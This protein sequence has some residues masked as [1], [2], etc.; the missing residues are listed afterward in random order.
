MK[1]YHGSGCGDPAEPFDDECRRPCP[2]PCPRFCPVPGPKGDTG[3]T[4][5]KGDMG[6]TG[7][8]GDTGATGPKGD[9]G[10]TGPKGDTGSTGPKG[11]TGATGPKGDMGV[12]TCPCRSRGELAVN[13]GMEA[14][15]G[16]VPTGWTM[17]NASLSSKV[18]QQGRVHSGNSAVNLENGAV[19]TQDI[20]ITGGCFYGLSFF[21]RGEGAQVGLTATLTFYNDKEEATPGLTITVRQ[22]DIPTD[23][24]NY[25][26]YRSVSAAAP[27]DA[28]TLRVQFKVTANG[29]QSLDL[30]DVSLV[31][32]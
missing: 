17:N 9:T 7:P 8:K 26:Y 5:P 15:T 16:S 24:R 29:E 10:T 21:A 14:F 19:L 2:C 25:A 3:A 32:A 23:N 27:D 6:A 20:D 18:T 22:Q 12:C 4:G 30:D 28:V 13:G 1:I 11:D 31:I